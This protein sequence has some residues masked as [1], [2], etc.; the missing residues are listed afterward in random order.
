MEPFPR[1]MIYAITKRVLALL[2]PRVK[3]LLLTAGCL[4]LAVPAVPGLSWAA[5]VHAQNQAEGATGKAPEFEVASIRLV[6][7]HSLDDV[8]RGVGA[9]SISP[10]PTNLFVARYV[11][12]T[13]LI[14]LA[15]GVDDDRIAGKPAWLD[16]QLY[17]VSAKVEGDTS[18]TREQMQPLLQ[19]L[20]KQRFGLAVHP[21]SR[22]VPG[23]ALVVGKGGPKL[24]PSKEGEQTHGQILP[25]GLEFQACNLGVLASILARPAGRPVVDETG[26]AGKYDVKLAYAPAD[27][28]NSDLPSVFTAV[29]GLGLKLEPRKV[30]VKTLVVDHVNRVPTEN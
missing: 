8:M 24:E 12:L 28:A 25:N 6:D 14:A 23:Y 11:S 13:N 30:P 1:G 5:R 19:Q 4:A 9:F 18:L 20:L 3:T 22:T 7:A 29:Q 10:F 21:E 15:Y 27:D 2:E 16:F 26:I 17:I